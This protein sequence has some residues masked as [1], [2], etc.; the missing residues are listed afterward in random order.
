MV[1]IFDWYLLAS[2]MLEAPS[3]AW[4]DFLKGWKMKAATMDGSWDV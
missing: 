1:L 3:D 4:L 2:V